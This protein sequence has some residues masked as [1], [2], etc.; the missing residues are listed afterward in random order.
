MIYKTLNEVESVIALGKPE[1]VIDVF[2]GSYLQGLAYEAWADGKDLEETEEVVVGQDED[3]KDIIE[4]K[5][6]HVYE[7]VDVGVKAWKKENYAILRQAFYP[8]MAEYLD[9][10]V[11]GDEEAIEAYKE[12]C[13]AVKERF[14]K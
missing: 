7:E 5:L 9:A 3:E 6:V 10:V 1:E 11:K 8:N 13:L 14:P 2:V 4:T 12:A